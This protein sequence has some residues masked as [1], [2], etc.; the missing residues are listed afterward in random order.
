MFYATAAVEVAVSLRLVALPYVVDVGFVAIVL[1]VSGEMA[2]RPLGTAHPRRPSSA[3]RYGFGS[4]G[5]LS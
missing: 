1:A 5:K 3:T 2:R 4:W